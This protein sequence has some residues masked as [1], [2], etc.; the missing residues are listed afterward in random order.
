M[1][2]MKDIAPKLRLMAMGK[3]VSEE[4][5][6][7]LNLVDK[8]ELAST[9][10]CSERVLEILAKDESAWVRFSVATNPTTPLGLIYSWKGLI[11]DKN[12][13]VREGVFAS[14]SFRE[15]NKE[16]LIKFIKEES[17]KKVLAAFFCEVDFTT[18]SGA[19]GYLEHLRACKN[20][21][22]K[23]GILS[24]EDIDAAVVGYMR[25]D[26]N[27]EVRI[28]ALRNSK[29]TTFVLKD[30]KKKDISPEVKA[31][32]DEELKKRKKKK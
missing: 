31:A 29:I 9:A 30:M 2:N 12:N 7:Q 20:V 14:K 4:A 3:Y 21:S 19:Q 13:M 6:Q 5:I 22:L 11:K 8:E 10:G 1:H 18:Q 26:P 24:R 25:K 16:E 17:D 27:A 15:L 32:A 28:A 23:V